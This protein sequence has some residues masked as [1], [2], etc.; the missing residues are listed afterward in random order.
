MYIFLVLHRFHAHNNMLAP[1]PDTTARNYS[2]HH[3]I[4][5]PEYLFSELLFFYWARLWLEHIDVYVL[6]S[7]SFDIFHLEKVIQFFVTTV[8]YVSLKR[9]LLSLNLEKGKM[10]AAASPNVRR[11]Q[12]A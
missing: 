5:E 8:C 9:C 12:K 6:S 10:W 11:M 1:Q 4:G 3:V 7:S 2:Y